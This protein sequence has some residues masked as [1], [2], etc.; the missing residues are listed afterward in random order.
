MTLTKNSSTMSSS[1]RTR[2]VSTAF[3]QNVVNV[4][5]ILTVFNTSSQCASAV[6]V[7][8][9]TVTA[10]GISETSV[11]SS[12][13]DADG[14]DIVGEVAVDKVIDEM[15]KDRWV[16]CDDYEN[17]WTDYDC[18]EEYKTIQ[19]SVEI[20]Y[21]EDV[22]DACLFLHSY[23]HMCASNRPHYHEPFVHYPARFLDR[24]ERVLFIGGGDSMVLHEVLKYPSLQLV[25]GLELDQA[26]V[27]TTF[28]FFGTQPHWDDERVQWYYGDGAKSLN[29]LPR[30]YYGTFDL[31]VVDILSPV[32]EAL[33]VNAELTVMEASMLL[34]KPDGIIIKN[35]DEGFKPGRNT[36]N[37]TKYSVDIMFHDVPIYCLQTFVVG[38]NSMDFLDATPKDHGVETLYMK[39][40][41]EF[42]SQFDSYYNTNEKNLM[43]RM[44]DRFS[45]PSASS[46]AHSVE[47]KENEEDDE[48][49]GKEDENEDVATEIYRRQTKKSYMKIQR[50]G[51]PIGVNMIVEAESIKTTEGGDLPFQSTSVIV[52]TFRPILT[53][54][55]GFVIVHTSESNFSQD[56]FR[57]NAVTFVFDQGY[58]VVRCV[59]EVQYCGFDVQLWADIHKLPDMKKALLSGV[60]NNEEDKNGAS[61]FRV[62]TSGMVDAKNEQSDLLGPPSVRE[63]CRSR[64][65]KQDQQ[66][67]TTN[68][69]IKM[70]TPSSLPATVKLAST[71]IEEREFRNMTLHSYDQTSARRQWKSQRMV[72][73][74]TI[75]QYEQEFVDDTSLNTIRK[76]LKGVIT[77]YGVS[78]QEENMGR[79][80]NIP[81]KPR[82]DKFQVIDNVSGKG[83]IMIAS[84]ASGHAI[85][86]WNGGGRFDVN[87]F[88]FGVDVDIQDTLMA[89]FENAVVFMLPFQPIV[90]DE[91]PRGTG[92]VINYFGDYED[93]DEESPIW[94]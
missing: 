83:S 90:R 46:T 89:G 56:E 12:S 31:V 24:V 85:V 15:Y 28:Q 60:G 92:H 42:Q 18:I 32:A 91:F 84:W 59:P 26:V 41:N 7:S 71:P 34:L 79:H 78:D 55:L 72:G 70:K 19:Q 30:E 11:A 9:A 87:F 6:A 2:R 51:A 49:E 94:F 4:V 20:Y 86:L 10:T 8:T 53:D 52:S 66:L 80:G 67:P 64:V 27:R 21:D 13:T 57:A 36:A 38:S 16:G 65:P 75:Q 62:V 61:E 17:V 39:D 29:V 43:D 50:E 40:V 54:E 93:R 73:L 35:E 63:Y 48:E 23:L 44:C 3:L 82:I 58:V 76:I 1:S 33:K 47:E 68:T 45:S 74:Q 37:F 81:P 25:V 14:S 22:D 69:T 88:V 5:A 77:Q